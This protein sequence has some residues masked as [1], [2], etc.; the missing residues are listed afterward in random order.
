[1]MKALRF[2]KDNLF[3]VGALC[4]A[5]IAAI[6]AYGSSSSDKLLRKM[7]DNKKKSDQEKLG[8]F[9]EKLER[10]QEFQEIHDNIIS[11]AKRKEEEITMEQKEELE[12]RRSEYFNADTPEKRQKVIDDI[13]N[14]FGELNYVPL[15]SIATVENKDD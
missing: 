9:K 8:I 15:D 7:F 14:N 6:F 1:M 2:I 13:Q 3:A 4:G 12:R 11:E 10:V 5:L